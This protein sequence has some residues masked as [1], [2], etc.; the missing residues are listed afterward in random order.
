MV[1]NC[2][3]YS[4]LWVRWLSKELTT[5]HLAKWFILSPKLLTPC[6]SESEDF[7][8]RILLW[9]AMKIWMQYI[10]PENKLDSMLWAHHMSPR[11][12][13][14]KTVLSPKKVLA[15][16]FWNRYGV[17]QIECF[18]YGN[19]VNAD[20]YC[21]LRRA[22]QNKCR[23]LLSCGIILL[24]ENTMHQVAMKAKNLLQTFG[25]SI[26]AHPPHFW[27]LTP[28]DFHLFLK[29][30]WFL[31][32]EK[33]SSNDELIRSVS[34]WLCSHGATFYNAGISKLISRL[35]RSLNHGGDIVEK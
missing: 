5:D 19:T 23:G 15:S 10:H 1:K 9:C 22:I 3:S 17:L 16:V 25:W 24:M 26:L 11:V 34:D 33:F 20:R 29:L 14:F 32:F 30:K 28:S 6:K 27:D 35:D 13:K 18:S 12:K 31:K 8:D 21:K 4:K 2:L 7:L